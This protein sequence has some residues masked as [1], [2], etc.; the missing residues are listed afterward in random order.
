M[1]RNGSQD[2]KHLISTCEEAHHRPSSI[3]V[4]IKVPAWDSMRHTVLGLGSISIV[5]GT[6]LTGY[7]IHGV[8]VHTMRCC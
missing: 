2:L 4:D 8:I 5:E 3:E 7:A 6:L 1:K